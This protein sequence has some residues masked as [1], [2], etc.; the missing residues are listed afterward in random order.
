MIDA[1]QIALANEIFSAISPPAN[2]GPVMT[3]GSRRM[4]QF[5]SND[6]LGLS[7]HREVRR[8]ASEIVEKYGIGAP[9]GSRLMSGTTEWHVELERRLAT[10]KRTESALIFATGSSATIGTLGCLATA[11]DVIIADEFAHASL[12]C[13]AKI[14]GAR[15][16]VFRHNDMGHLESLLAEYSDVGAMAIVV[17]GVYSMQ[18]DRAPIDEIV[19]LAKDYGAR[20]I[21]DDAHGTGACGEHG[22]GTASIFGM[23]DYVDIQLGT[24]SKAFGTTG[25][26]VVGDRAVIEYIRFHA[27][28]FVFTKSLSLAVVAA[29]I[30][31]LELLELADE[32]R[33]R[34]AKN[35]HQLQRGLKKLG[36]RIGQTESPITPIAFRGSEAIYV[37]HELRQAYGIW[38]A[39]VIYPAVPLGKS[40]IR[41]IPTSQHTAAQIDYLLESLAM[42]RASMILGSMPVA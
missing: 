10:F 6:Y 4:L 12:M 11:K 22:R 39:P 5:S 15:M 17:D 42:V 8:R 1:E 16:A 31:S 35:T 30:K 14:S 2:A 9:F 41:V 34:L 32:C 23:E 29:T 37:A 27:P 18:G 36:F 24:F 38:V 28:T 21:V 7:V 40:I 26:F 25:G 3:L 20:L 13:G 33:A 19:P